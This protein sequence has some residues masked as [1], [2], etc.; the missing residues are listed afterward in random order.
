MG[1]LEAEASRRLKF[2]RLEDSTGTSRTGKGSVRRLIMS[3]AKRDVINH[4][5]THDATHT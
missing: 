1:L 5:G 3:M 2:T 4:R